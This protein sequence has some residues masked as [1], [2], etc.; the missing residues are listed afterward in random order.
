MKNENEKG[1]EKKTNGPLIEDFIAF[2][3]AAEEDEKTR[4]IFLA[5]VPKGKTC[6]F[7]GAGC[8][9]RKYSNTGEKNHMLFLEVGDESHKN[10]G[11]PAGA[12]KDAL[13]NTKTRAEEAGK[14]FTPELAFV[15]EGNKSM[16]FIGRGERDE[17]GDIPLFFV[18]GDTGMKM[19]VQNPPDLE[20]EL[21]TK[22]IG[23]RYVAAR[24]TDFSDI[25]SI[26]GDLLE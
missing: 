22:T 4:G 14:T 3:E 13:E 6:A 20:Q 19:N 17:E 16:Y 2:L 10:A 15:N 9:E 23:E 21:S 5:L 24:T 1:T 8:L 11:S 7:G 12:I 25:M 26:F 18:A